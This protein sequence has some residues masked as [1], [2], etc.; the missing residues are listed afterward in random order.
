VV[1][2]PF[3]TL[4]F[5]TGPAAEALDHV[6][7]AWIVG[8][9]VTFVVYYPLAKAKAKR[10]QLTGTAALGEEVL[11]AHALGFTPVPQRMRLS[12]H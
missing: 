7:V 6:D 11:D 5:Y 8:L 4:T 2:I 9:I 10:T 3:F 1:Q 12:Q